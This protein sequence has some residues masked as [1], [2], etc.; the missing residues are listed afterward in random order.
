MTFRLQYVGHTATHCNTLQNQH[1]ATHSTLQ[2]VDTFNTHRQIRLN[3]HILNIFN[4]FSHT[5]S[6]MTAAQHLTATQSK[7]VC[8]DIY[9][10][11]IGLQHAVTRIWLQHKSNSVCVVAYIH[12]VAYISI[13]SH[14]HIWLQ[15]NATLLTATRCNTRQQMFWRQR[16][17]GGYSRE[18]HGGGGRGWPQLCMGKGGLF[19]I[20][21]Y[22]L[23]VS[24]P[25]YICLHL[26]I[27]GYNGRWK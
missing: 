27:C 15:H 26:C 11:D 4:T 22:L 14:T 24:I 3:Y 16:F 20:Y 5:H 6:D 9:C 13:Y 1:T 21:L 2:Y 23:S 19:A 12:F 10:V 17:Y 8:V 18:R 25:I 7:S